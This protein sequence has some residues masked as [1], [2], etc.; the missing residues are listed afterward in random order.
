M[1]LVDVNGTHQRPLTSRGLRVVVLSSGPF[2]G[3]AGQPAT[4]GCLRQVAASGPGEGD[5]VG[6]EATAEDAAAA[7][8]RAISS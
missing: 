5:G 2:L 3:T 4:R 6:V 7:W 1:F 8:S